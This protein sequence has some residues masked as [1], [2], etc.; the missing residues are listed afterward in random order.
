METIAKRNMLVPGWAL[1]LQDFTHHSGKILWPLSANALD[2]YG[3]SHRA[4]WGLFEWCEFCW[5]VRRLF[6]KHGIAYRTHERSPRR[7]RTVGRCAGEHSQG[8]QRGESCN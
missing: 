1:V 4:K 8:D 6:A 7:G 3:L 5:S 2:P